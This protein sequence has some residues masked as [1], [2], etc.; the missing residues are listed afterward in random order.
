MN[1]PSTQ[2]LVSNTILQSKELGLLGA[3][4]HSGTGA[5]NIHRISLEH[6]V[7]PESKEVLKTNKQTHIY[8]Q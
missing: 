7:G 8:T 4:V 5:E 6:F 2:I 3:V 1:V